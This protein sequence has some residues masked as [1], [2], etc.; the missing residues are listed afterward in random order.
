M[1][2]LGERVFS[3]RLPPLSTAQQTSVK[4]FEKFLSDDEIAALKEAA[5]TVSASSGEVSR[6]NGCQEDSWR[7]IFFNHRLAE[8][9]PD[10]HSRLVAAAKEADDE[11]GLLDSE[12]TQV[13]MRC[14]EYHSV[15]TSGGLPK[16]KHY[17]AGSLIT[18]DLMLSHTDEFDGGDFSTLEQDGQL[19]PHKFERG[20]L[21]VF[22]SHK[23]H[24]VSPVTNGT[25]QVFVCE[26]WE[27]LERRCPRRCNMPF[28]PCSCRLDALITRLDEDSR[29]NLAEVPFT[30]NTPVAI[31]HAWTAMRRLRAG[32]RTAKTRVSATRMMAAPAE[33][34]STTLLAADCAVLVVV[35]LLSSSLTALTLAGLDFASPTFDLAADVRSFDLGATAQYI[36][37]EQLTASSPALGWLVGGMASDACGEGWSTREDDARWASLARGYAIALPLALVLKYGAL[38]ALDLPTLG[39]SAQAMALEQRLAGLSAP[40]AISDALA[41]LGT[42]VLWRQ[43]LHRNPDL[44]R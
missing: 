31:K 36:G 21:L 19:Q 5:A 15:Q 29:T 40:N 14:A 34:L 24:C 17:D 10:L 13:S 37:V 6:S 30:R 26:L 42:L 38:S 27:G 35:S 33:P 7:T 11:W 8:L 20:D 28:G 16:P 1:K 44:L 12:R 9:L 39:R 22:V 41:M 32:T 4:R 23:F 43:V 3:P 25:R 18:L 2:P